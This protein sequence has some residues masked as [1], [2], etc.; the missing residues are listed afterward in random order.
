MT[1]SLLLKCGNLDETKAFYSAI[2]GFDVFDSAEGSC[3]VRKSEGTIIFTDG[4]LW[5]GRPHCTGTIYFFVPDVDGYYRAV[6]DKAIVRWP[7]ENMSY[8]TR[9]F[10]IKDCNGYT[11]AFAQQSSAASADAR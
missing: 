9:E 7:L 1:M 3:T 2:L 10:G 6:K 5:E 4:E 11:L 8:G